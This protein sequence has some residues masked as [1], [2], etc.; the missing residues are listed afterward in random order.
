MLKINPRSGNISENEI[1]AVSSKT[2]TVMWSKSYNPGH[3]C[4]PEQF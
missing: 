3:D 1:R 4:T 2:V